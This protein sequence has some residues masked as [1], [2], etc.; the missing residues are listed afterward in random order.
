MSKPLEAIRIAEPTHRA[1]T[2]GMA[3][4]GATTL[5]LLK[6]EWAKARSLSERWIAVTTSGDVL[7]QLPFAISCS[8]W[9]L[10]Q[11]GEANRP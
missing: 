4:L 7:L 6:G 9:V 11:L 10:A 5:R 8:A 3:H 2:I 1:I